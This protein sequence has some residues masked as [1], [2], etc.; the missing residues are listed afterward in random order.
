MDYTIFL[1]QYKAASD[2]DAIMKKHITKDYISY[3][4]KIEEAK[5]IVNTANTQVID[6]KKKSVINSPN[7]YFLFMCRLL[8]L[9][10]DIVWDD[11]NVVEAF[12][13]LNKEGVF[14]VFMRCL[15]PREYAEFDTVVRMVQDDYM[16]NY[17]S[18]V[19]FLD[20]KIDA[21]SGAMNIILDAISSMNGDDNVVQIHQS[22]S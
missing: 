1:T 11:N 5:Q 21:V 7:R 8:K 17:M 4:K 18:I 12:D 15:P 10:T 16:I 19:P 13:A 6:E 20:T 2:K 3:V 22:E 14:D 9:Y